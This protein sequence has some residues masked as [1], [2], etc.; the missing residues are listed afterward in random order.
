MD[1]GRPVAEEKKVGRWAGGQVATEQA[2]DREE[3]QHVHGTP[4]QVADTVL[5]YGALTR[6]L[7]NTPALREEQRETAP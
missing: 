4:K 5:A 2:A 1:V 7:A 6:L 3:I